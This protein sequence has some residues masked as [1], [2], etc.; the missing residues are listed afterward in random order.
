MI[1]VG[2]VFLATASLAA[3]TVT[4]IILSIREGAHARE[5]SH[6]INRAGAA[7]RRA[8]RAEMTAADWEH[9]CDL[10]R[11]DAQAAERHAIGLDYERRTS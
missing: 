7:E 5:V 8:A 1:N 11:T 3:L 6:L 4:A 9:R 10:W 2:L